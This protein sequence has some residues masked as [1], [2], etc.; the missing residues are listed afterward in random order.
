MT[1]K[2]LTA[3]QVLSW[4]PSRVI[5]WTGKEE[6]VPEEY[7]DI[8]EDHLLHL[9]EDKADSNPEFLQHAQRQSIV[10]ICWGLI[11]QIA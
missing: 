4:I 11:I 6:H 7:Y 8:L 5:C 9:F 10:F 3:Y 2:G 1:Y